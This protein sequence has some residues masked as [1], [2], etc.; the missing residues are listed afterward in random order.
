MIF[1]V[2]CH[3]IGHLGTTRTAPRSPEVNEHV[4][5]LANPLAELAL[6]AL[7]VVHH[8]FGEH[9]SRLAFPQTFEHFLWTCSHRMVIVSGIGTENLRKLAERQV[10]Y[11]VGEEGEGSDIIPVGLDIVEV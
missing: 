10:I 8:E 9:H 4:V 11:H 3:H 1:L 7:G 2:G 5:A 6:L